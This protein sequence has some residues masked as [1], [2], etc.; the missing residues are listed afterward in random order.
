MGLLKIRKHKKLKNSISSKFHWGLFPWENAHIT[1]LDGEIVE[2]LIRSQE[3]Y[4]KNADA[5]QE[6]FCE[7]Y[8][9]KILDDGLW[10]IVFCN[11]WK[12]VKVQLCAELEEED[13]Y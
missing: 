2:V 3:D 10:N 1:F 8:K 4:L 6:T 5:V 13:A 11:Q 9:E 7:L 12:K